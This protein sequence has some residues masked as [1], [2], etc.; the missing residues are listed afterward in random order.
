VHG[1]SPRARPFAAGY[2]ELLVTVN[3]RIYSV[4]TDRALYVKGLRCRLDPLQHPAHRDHWL[5]TATMVLMSVL[6]PIKV[7]A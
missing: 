7:F 5:R 2:V 4:G 6:T 1:Q 3:A